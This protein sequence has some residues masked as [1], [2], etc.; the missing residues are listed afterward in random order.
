MTETFALLWPSQV[1]IVI[2]LMII[3]IIINHP[4]VF[5]PFITI[6]HRKNSR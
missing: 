2:T 6:I 5:K 4:S 1:T 3:I